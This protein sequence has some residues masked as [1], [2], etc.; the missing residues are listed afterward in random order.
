MI[1]DDGSGWHS[2]G[3]DLHLSIL[4][5]LKQ[6]KDKDS[7]QAVMQSSRDL[8]LL[9]SS[10]ISAIEIRDASALAHYPRHAAAIKSIQLNMR[11][12][13]GEAHME[14]CCM[15][16]WLQATSAAGNR[17]AAV[18]I[19]HIELPG[20]PQ[21]DEEGDVFTMDPATMDSLLASIGRACPDLRSL[22]MDNIDRT[23]E[24]LVRAILTAIGQHL[25]RIIELQLELYYEAETDEDEDDHDDFA[26][27]GIDWAA[28]LPRGLQKFTSMV[29]LHHELL[30]QLVLMPALKEVSVWC[31]STGREELLEVQSDACA[32]RIL[33]LQEGFPSCLDLGRFSSAMPLLHLICQ[34]TLF[35]GAA[36]KGPAV[37][38]RAAAWLSQIRNSP[39]ELDLVFGLAT[40]VSTAGLISSLA[41][42][43]SMVSLQLRDWPV[44]EGTLDELAFAFPNVCKLTLRSGSIS[45]GAWARMPSLTSVTKLTIYTISRVLSRTEGTVISLAQIIAF[46]SAVSHPMTLTL[47]GGCVSPDDQA[48]WKAFEAEQRRNN[49]LQ[50]ITVRITQ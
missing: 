38:A 21:P 34:P 19:V 31:L 20:V 28:C 33:R 32:W 40:T 42:L 2:L 6:R 30:Q 12:S 25:P 44:T 9:A 7:L 50:H 43:S 5:V 10:L 39:E 4:S 26:I 17:L 14:P 15:V 29:D 46:T 48:S 24:D 13:H 16:S 35:L 11:P 22:R 1:H 47:K 27:A 45:R 8:R 49:G 18:T 36:E 37:V 23:D 41:P 3:H